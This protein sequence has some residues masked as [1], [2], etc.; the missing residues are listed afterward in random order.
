MDM[1][2]YLT[3]P[4]N[5]GGLTH[6]QIS[7]LYEKLLGFNKTKETKTNDW[8]EKFKSEVIGKYYVWNSTDYIITNVFNIEI[9]SYSNTFCVIICTIKCYPKFDDEKIIPKVTYE[10]GLDGLIQIK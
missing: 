7:E 8:I 5:Y 2:D 1:I 9:I 10:M 4:D 3:N 6:S